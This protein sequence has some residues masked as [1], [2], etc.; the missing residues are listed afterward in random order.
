MKDWANQYVQKLS[1]RQINATQY[2]MKSNDNAQVARSKMI[3]TRDCEEECM[4]KAPRTHTWDVL[5]NVP[6]PKLQL[7]PSPSSFPRVS[8]EKSTRALSFSF[9][10]FPSLFPPFLLFCVFLR[11]PCPYPVPFAAREQPTWEQ[12]EKQQKI[13]IPSKLQLLG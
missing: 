8:P 9:L 1:I 11:K 3:K 7:I 13:I 6:P 5:Q 10:P 2:I 4:R 12:L